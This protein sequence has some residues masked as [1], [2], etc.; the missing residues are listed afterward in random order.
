MSVT[1]LLSVVLM[2]TGFAVADPVMEQDLTSDNIPG[3]GSNIVTLFGGYVVAW[4][5]HSDRNGHQFVHLQGYNDQG[6]RLGESVTICEVRSKT[7]VPEIAGGKLNNRFMVAVAF[8]NDIYRVD[9]LLLEYGVV[10]LS[11]PCP[12]GTDE[13]LP[14][15]YMI[16]ITSN[17]NASMFAVVSSR[18][19]GLETNGIFL[20]IYD[21]GEFIEEPTPIHVSTHQ[22]RAQSNPD[23]AI[24]DDMTTVIVWRDIQAHGIYSM[25][26]S[27]QGYP[28]S[29]PLRVTHLAENASDPTVGSL[30]NGYILGW[31]DT[32]SNWYS[33][34][35]GYKSVVV[36]SFLQIFSNDATK[37]G[38]KILVSKNEEE[39]GN[40]L[41]VV[42]CEDDTFWAAYAVDGHVF[43]K[44]FDLSGK[45]VQ[46][47]VEIRGNITPSYQHLRPGL[48]NHG[49][50]GLIVTFAS[51]DET[52]IST[53]WWSGEDHTGYPTS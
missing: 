20:R 12:V 45:Q 19:D 32:A 39:T 21:G 42:G 1:V 23:V 51:G 53:Y 15:T 22:F 16:R 24:L 11:S 29:R 36:Q 9:G 8:N 18:F 50:T 47:E 33:D 26:Y 41:S 17:Q 31:K 4:L 6:K 30:N 48:A 40:V 34:A 14:V 7:S 25:R 37:V 38:E 49:A 13:L 35:S 10:L 44:H 5:S 43:A 3:A 27:R 52:P 28:L 46:Q 2:L